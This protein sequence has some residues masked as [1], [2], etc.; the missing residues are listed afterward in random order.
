MMVVNYVE[1]KPVVKLNVSEKRSLDNAIGIL[2]MIGSIENYK[3]Q[4]AA[5]IAGL[6]DVIE[7][8]KPKE[9]K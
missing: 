5:A 1:G 8:M 3:A 2:S 6:K 7:L 9:K 4:S